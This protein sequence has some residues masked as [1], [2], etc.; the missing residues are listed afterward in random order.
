MSPSETKYCV[1]C[2]A[3]GN[4]IEAEF[5]VKFNGD[6]IPVCSYHNEL[7]KNENLLDILEDEQPS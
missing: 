7:V 4:S 3:E 2:E 5:F 6:L 1:L